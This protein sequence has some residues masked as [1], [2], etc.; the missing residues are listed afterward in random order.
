MVGFGSLLG[1]YREGGAHWAWYWYDFALKVSDLEAL[2]SMKLISSQWFPNATLPMRKSS[3]Q[4][5]IS[6][7]L[8]LTLS[9]WGHETFYEC[10][11][12]LK[13][14]IG[15]PTRLMAY[16][17]QLPLMEITGP[18]LCIRSWYCEIAIAICPYFMALILWSQ[19]LTIIGKLTWFISKF[20]LN[21]LAKPCSS[22]S[23]SLPIR[24]FLCYLVDATAL[25]GLRVLHLL[26]NPDWWLRRLLPL[27][28]IPSE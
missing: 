16:R 8:L 9:S 24:R 18:R 7:G 12:W 26:R 20:H 14:T 25:I 3:N 19:T 10:H 15:Q 28:S 17:Y 5:M 13:I 6:M 23:P 2:S 27:T 21:Q 1:Y 11:H 4:P 22:K